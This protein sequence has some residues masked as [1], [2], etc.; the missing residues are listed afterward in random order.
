MQLLGLGRLAEIRP[1]LLR[2]V[3]FGPGD[4]ATAG[5]GC[6]AS[7]GAGRLGDVRRVRRSGGWGGSDRAGLGLGVRGLGGDCEMFNKDKGSPVGFR[8]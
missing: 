8:F 6:A 3:R 5:R 7:P 1:G 4:H 2:L